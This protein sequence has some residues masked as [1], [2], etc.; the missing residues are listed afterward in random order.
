[1]AR[2]TPTYWVGDALSTASYAY[3]LR[4]MVPLLQHHGVLVRPVPL[5]LQPGTIQQF[6]PWWKQWVASYG[7]PWEQA[8]SQSGRFVYQLVPA[9]PLH[10]V[11]PGIFFTGWDARPYPADWV[12]V[13]NHHQRLVTWSQWSAQVAQESGVTIPISVI[14]LPW[15]EAVERY[16]P[17]VR[18]PSSGKEVTIGLMGQAVPRKRLLESLLWLWETFVP[19]DGVRIVAKIGPSAGISMGDIYRHLVFTKQRLHAIPPTFLWTGEWSVSQR[20]AFFRTCDVFVSASTGEGFG[21]PMVEA[22]AMGCALVVPAEAGGWGD[23]LPSTHPMVARVSGQWEPLPA[24]WIPQWQQAGMAGYFVKKTDWQQAVWT[25]VQ[26]K[27]WRDSAAVATFAMA[28]RTGSDPD[29]IVTQWQHVL[30][31]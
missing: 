8:L 17:S 20:D 6:D 9:A 27:P 26:Q 14:P 5:A 7:L 15:Y 13:L 18:T 28:A 2:V 3:A 10:Q 23:W 4:R 30:A 16:A 21:L 31:T 1:M 29:K 11:H 25:M 12:Q 22:A 19:Q 24:G